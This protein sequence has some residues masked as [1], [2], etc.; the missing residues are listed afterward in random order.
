MKA[1]IDYIIDSDPPGN[2]ICIARNEILFR[3]MQST[4]DALFFLDSDIEFESEAFLRILTCPG[5]I[6]V[7][8][9]PTKSLNFQKLA[10]LISNRDPEAVSKAMNY[11]LNISKKQR[12]GGETVVDIHGFLQLDD[13]A[14][15]FMRIKRS[16]IG[17]LMK[18]TPERQY[19]NDLDKAQH[20][21]FNNDF[22]W[23]NERHRQIYR[24]EDYSFCA[25]ARK[26]GY[27]VYASMV[28]EFVHHGP[29]GFHGHWGKTLQRK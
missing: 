27:K 4:A 19:F 6:S 1:K 24:G 9:Y 5:D 14:T 11:P 12:L 3:F 10:D 28:D 23:C 16:V 20:A 8:V 26:H 2:G 29:Y 15:G 13:G 18:K 25:L 21:L 17:Q 7:G 22:V